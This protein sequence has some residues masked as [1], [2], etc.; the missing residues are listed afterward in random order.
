METDERMQSGL[1]ST[2]QLHISSA[3]SLNWQMDVNGYPID[4][5]PHFRILRF[6]LLN[7]FQ[8][9]SAVFVG[10]ILIRLPLLMSQMTQ[11]KPCAKLNVIAITV[12][13]CFFNVSPKL[14]CQRLQTLDRKQLRD[15]RLQKVPGTLQCADPKSL[16]NSQNACLFNDDSNY[17]NSPLG[18]KHASPGERL[19]VM[20]TYSFLLRS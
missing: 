13:S 10:C 11:L 16:L 20:L 6:Q 3:I 12:F 8:A 2:D 17:S 18:S 14:I 1:R 19:S 15:V 5:Y 7:F 4:G 9:G